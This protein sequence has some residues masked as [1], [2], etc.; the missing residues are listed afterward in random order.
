VQVAVAANFAAPMQAIGAEFERGT[1]HRLLISVGASGQFYAQIR[2]GAPFAVFLSADDET[3]AKLESEGW[4]VSGSRF[5]Y[6]IGRLAL[7]SKKTDLVDDRGVVLQTG[8]ISKL[9]IA[10]PVLAPYGAA[11]MQV[12]NRLGLRERL[13]PRIVQGANIS[14][15]YQFVA[16]ENAPLGFVALSQIMQNG[17]ITQGSAWLVPAELHDPIRQDAVLLAAGREQDAA[18]ALLQFLQGEK[19]RAIMRRHGYEF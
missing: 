7:W 15:V 3:P 19:A 9:A 17:Q 8:S 13:A 10:H 5:T 18:K 4:A 11:A 14:Q 1:G 6:A 2:N 16:T 12:L